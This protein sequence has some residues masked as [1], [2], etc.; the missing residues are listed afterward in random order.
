MSK[1]EELR[2]LEEGRRPKK[3]S[4]PEPT[5]P[6]KPSA[7]RYIGKVLDTMVTSGQMDM[8]EVDDAAMVIASNAEEG[9]EAV[10]NA[11]VKAG[12]IKGSRLLKGG[13]ARIRDSVMGA[14]TEWVLQ[15][16]FDE[17]DD[18]LMESM[19]TA[20]RSMAGELESAIRETIRAK[21]KEMGHADLDIDEITARARRRARGV[22]RKLASEAS[23]RRYRA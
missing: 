16:L 1:L 23:K 21:L 20:A 15:G 7:M 10:V 9:P 6:P 3:E 14:M 13:H 12:H 5:E 18:A 22:A 17:Q 4:S 11:L 2:M 8:D 19:S